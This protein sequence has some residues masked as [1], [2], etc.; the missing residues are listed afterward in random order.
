ML[1][2]KNI[3]KIYQV[4]SFKQ[5]ALNGVSVSFRNN[6]FVAI[7]GP[8]GSGKTTLLNIIGGL[9]A[10]TD[11]DLIIDG[12][13]T[14]QFRD[15]DW[16][17]YRNNKIGFVFQSYNLIPHQTIL[18]NVEL[19]LTL[20][21]IS[22]EERHHRALDALD[23]VG[24]R[25]HASKK[26][27]Q[28]S[29]GQMQRVAIARA[30]INDPD[31]LLADE[32]TG[33]LDSKTSITI[34]DLLS[35]IAK[36]RLVIMVTHNPELA[37]EYANR[38]ITIADGSIVDDSNPFSTVDASANIPHSAA[39]PVP[40]SNNQQAPSSTSSLR[41]TKMSFFTALSLSA[42][43]LL[44]KKGRTIMTA[45]AG[46][47]GIIGIA[48]ILS[49]ANGVNNYIKSVEEDTLSVY[50]LQVMS[51][52][53]DISAMFTSMSGSSDTSSDQDGSNAPVGLFNTSRG[54]ITSGDSVIHESKSMSKLFASI[55]KND[56]ASLKTF[57]ASD[58]SN[59]ADQVS[60]IFFKYDVTPQIF[61]SNTEHSIR[62][63][64]PD[65][66]FA[67]LGFD[68]SAT[69]N[70]L[71]SM[72]MSSDIFSEMPNDDGTIKG[73]YDIVSGRWPEGKQELVVVL[74][75]AGTISDFMAYA[76]GL[77][78]PEKLKNMV[79]QFSDGEEIDVE[80][81]KLDKTYNDLVG[82]SF[83][84][85]N[86]YQYYRYDEEHKIW[87]NKNNDQ[88]YMRDLVNNGTDLTIVGVVCP[89][90]DANAVALS[91]GIY[92]TPAL[93][94][95]LIIQAQQSDIVKDQ[96]ADSKRDVITGELFEDEQARQSSFDMSSLFSFDQEAFNDLFAMD[97]SSL[98]LGSLDIGAL[99]FNPADMN[100]KDLPNIKFD[101][102]SIV[103][104]SVIKLS[105]IRNLFPE[106]TPENMTKGI[107][108]Q[109]KDPEAISS[110]IARAY[111]KWA[112]TAKDPSFIS[113]LNSKEGQ[114][115]TEGIVNSLDIQSVQDT[116]LKNLSTLLN[117]RTNKIGET[118]SKRIIDYYSSKLGSRIEKVFTKVMTTYMREAM[119]SLTKSLT[120]YTSQLSN[121]SK[122][123]AFSSSSLMGNNPLLS[124]DAL[125]DGFQV[126]MSE[127]D[128]ADMLS[129]LMR[130]D[131][132]SYEG[133]LKKMGYADFAKPSEIRIYPKDFQ[134]KEKI[135]G[136]LDDYNAR[137]SAED[138]DRVIS[139]TDIVGT[140]MRS[141]TTII[142]T[143]S[144]V[145]IAFVAIS[146]V[147]SSI[148]IGVI[149]YISVLERR[150]EIGI[151]RALGASKRDVANVF[152]A[153]TII[154]G[155]IAGV[156]GI[157]ITALVSIP[158]N[159]AVYNIYKVPNVSLLPIEAAL[160]LIGISVFLTFI[161][162]LIPSSSAS[163]K[164]PVE[165]LRSE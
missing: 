19:A 111:Q 91:S 60:N 22:R 126:N 145:L 39:K 47:I 67:S 66:S 34:M 84:V 131:T 93:V 100:P 28:L 141:V 5:K 104:P 143:L 109:F 64:N 63:I 123:P 57:L 78:D 114:K 115:L 73:Q 7:L 85:V 127:S 62:Q 95:D 83:K 161:S 121:L 30:L 129:S 150:K 101:P 157:S 3:S 86:S 23:S 53:F 140:M 117:T 162:G 118:I 12:M 14:K 37:E 52:G 9:D 74:S 51:S 94:D 18:E 149:T 144:A 13:S 146:L 77:R 119:N 15:R 24:L 103:D 122:L 112:Q 79:Q 59:I 164:D 25:E 29:G 128:I 70:S 56:L 107:Q 71:M 163:R 139:Y 154:E 2:I 4:G 21:G 20:S 97:L 116:L 44:T 38:I 142:D 69:S 41:K 92:Y 48:A 65:K 90:E 68:S 32:P 88:D 6:E 42:K 80:D 10:Y 8:S 55:G 43:N 113:F 11:G 58:E 125:K 26:P 138:P 54:S 156:L 81:T 105:D 130:P 159:I 36:N 96:L 135:I 137:M 50:P 147:V 89:K 76:L 165:A 155:L 153:E 152:N 1:Q 31:I 33:A 16:D 35:E 136:I 46:S 87:I 40:L 108:I 82:M 148:M 120:S 110:E 133:N 124:L 132:K 134:S 158:V 98:N 75:K 160:I 102:G 49:L 45:I 27:T 17:S 106:L 72:T 151:L 61:D 99:D